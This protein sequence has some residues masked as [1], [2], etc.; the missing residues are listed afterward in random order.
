MI[1]TVEI[2]NKGKLISSKEQDD[3]RPTVEDLEKRLKIIEDV[4][5]KKSKTLKG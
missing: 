4:V 3:G 1:S 2:W 5:N